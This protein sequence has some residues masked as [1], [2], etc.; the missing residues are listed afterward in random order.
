MTHEEST[1]GQEAVES[2]SSL[3]TGGGH[4]MPSVGFLPSEEPP[5]L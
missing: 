4:C 1:R 3:E 2:S 5:V